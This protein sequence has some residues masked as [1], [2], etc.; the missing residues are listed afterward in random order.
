MICAL[1]FL[2]A[3]WSAWTWLEDH[4]RWLRDQYMH[5]R[6][7]LWEAQQQQRHEAERRQRVLDA[8]ATAR[9]ARLYPPPVARRPAQRRPGQHM[10]VDAYG[11]IYG[12]DE[13]SDN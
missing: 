5:Q 13:S 9:F 1:L 4:E 12:G 6:A 3:V 10:W 7:A 8:A 11:Q 2:A